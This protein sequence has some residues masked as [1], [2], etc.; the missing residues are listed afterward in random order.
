[1]LKK[2]AKKVIPKSVLNLRHLY[3]AYKGAKM[4][5]HPS[6]ELFVIGITGTSGK[7]ST[8]Y[9]LRQILE[10]AGYKVGTLSTIDFYVAGEEKLNDQKM[11]ML[12]KMQIQKYL[13]KMVDAGCD[14]AIVETTSEGRV[15]HRHRFIN[16]DMMLLTN[17]YPEHIDSHGSF[18]NYRQAKLDIFE[19]VSKLPRKKVE[20]NKVLEKFGKN[21]IPKRSV[22]NTTDS[23]TGK[24]FLGYNF[25]E[26]YSYAETSALPE[27]KGSEIKSHLGLE[28]SE[29]TAEGLKFEVAGREY[30][31]PIFGK[32][33]IMNLICAI[34]AVK[35]IGVSEADISEALRSLKAAPGR[36]EFIKEAKE[37]GFS[38]IVDYAFE[39]VAIEELYKVVKLISPNKVIHVFGSTGGGRDI[40]RRF[41]V[42]EFVGKNADY[43][44]VTDE[45]PY[46]DDPMEIINDVASAASKSGKIEGENLFKI[47]DRSDAI[48]KALELAG[49]G[50]MILLTGKGSEQAMVVKGNLLPWDDREEVRKHLKNI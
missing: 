21:I 30:S 16:Y 14:I 46:D 6:E 20:G 32:Y 42:G 9:F 48:K 5:S 36:I 11:T 31:A 35:A 10:R 28:S 26:Q 43:C 3:Y 22:V 19:Y 41:S 33:N 25:D 24:L 40:A 29:I 18:E 23:M 4:Y 15:Q 49:E 27:G 1:M 45:D 38:V 37:K 47:L 34:S 39:P 44:I 2:L 7:S 8:T 12:G 13:R 50:D 17:L